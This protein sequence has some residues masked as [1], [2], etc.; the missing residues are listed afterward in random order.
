MNAV[1]L[2]RI[3]SSITGEDYPSDNQPALAQL[4]MGTL[5][6]KLH[7]PDIDLD[8]DIGGYTRVKGSAEEGNLQH[9]RLQARRSPP[10]TR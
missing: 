2:R 10:P 1:R 9:P 7:V 6:G 3:L 5:Q 4:R 8:R